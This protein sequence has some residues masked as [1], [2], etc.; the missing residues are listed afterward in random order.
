MPTGEITH[1]SGATYEV[2]CDASIY[3]KLATGDMSGA[4]QLAVRRL[5][6]AGLRPKLRV[7]IATPDVAQRLAASMAFGI[8]RRS[9]NR[10]A[11]SVT[12]AD[13]DP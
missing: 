8:D 4:F 9:L 1:P 2:T 11:L 12:A 13:E 6:N 5:A 10:L 7:G 3:R